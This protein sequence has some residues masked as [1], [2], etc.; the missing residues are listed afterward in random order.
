MKKLMC[1]A[2]LTA[3]SLCAAN[4]NWIVLEGDYGNSVN[5]DAGSIPTADDYGKIANGGICTL[6]DGDYTCQRVDLGDGGTGTL[7]QTGGFLTFSNYPSIG[8]NGATGTYLLSGGTL[9]VHGILRI[10]RRGPVKYG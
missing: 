9:T 10:G 7:R 8:Y 3:G 5:W 4:L 6:S 1:C 2:V